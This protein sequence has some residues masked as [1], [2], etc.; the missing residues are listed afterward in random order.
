MD[1][2]DRWAVYERKAVWVKA[3]AV[4]MAMEPSIGVSDMTYRADDES[5]RE[6]VEVEYSNGHKRVVDVTA[7]S[8]LA[9]MD[10]V[11]KVIG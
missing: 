7:D 1:K 10:D 11:R 2:E 3:M 5:R 6:T 8:F 9:I 4:L